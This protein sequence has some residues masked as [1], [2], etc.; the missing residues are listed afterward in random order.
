M[1]SPDTMCQT[2]SLLE[3]S[4]SLEVLST[5]L[6]SCLKIGPAAGLSVV[7]SAALFWLGQTKVPGAC[8]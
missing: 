5:Q 4:V 8:T 3:G 1:Q 6:R 7:V 2:V